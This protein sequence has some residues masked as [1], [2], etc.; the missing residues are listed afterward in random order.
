METLQA[1]KK[2][3]A[4]FKANMTRVRK[5]VDMEMENYAGPD[6]SVLEECL[7]DWRE[8][9]KKLQE[10]EVKVLC[11]EDA[12][13]Q[14]ADKDLPEI[15]VTF[16][17]VKVEINGYRRDYDAGLAAAQ[18][19]A[20]P[21]PNPQQGQQQQQRAPALPKIEIKKPPTLEEDTD[22]R[23]F[24]R[25][26]P[27]W[28]NYAKLV[29]LDK[30]VNGVQVGLFWECCSSGFLRIV[31]HGI[32][33]KT[34]TNRTVEEVLDMIND[35]LR[36]L[37]NPHLD[38]RDLL[39]VRQSEG[40]DYTSL[41]NELRELADYADTRTIT[42]DRLLIAILLQSM[43]DDHD[44][45]KVMEK[46]PGTFAAARKIILDLE[47]ARRG[48]R[49]IGSE[50]KSL[51]MAAAIRNKSIYQRAKENDRQSK[52]APKDCGQCGFRYH[53]RE[54]CPAKDVECRGC[55]RIGHYEK[56]CRSKHTAAAVRYRIGA[57]KLC[58]A[59]TRV[60]REPRNEDPEIKSQDGHD[61]KSPESPSRPSSVHRWK[62]LR[63]K[64]GKDLPNLQVGDNVLVQDRESLQWDRDATII[65]RDRRRYQIKFSSSG[66]VLFRNCRYIRKKEASVQGEADPVQDRVD[67]V[68]DGSI[69][70]EESDKDILVMK[71]ETGSVIARV[72]MKDY[73]NV[74]YEF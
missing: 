13:Q 34:G 8:S 33:I 6:P 63:R 14:D 1:L 61:P 54:D 48:A 51:D 43:E 37:R 35:H 59:G 20:N 58:I 12:T 3:R 45:A 19:P 31:N 11:H 21:P 24:A 60:A 41:C 23:A 65:G 71:T 56:V 25:W 74:P 68:Q 62:R 47:T 17:R 66:T 40:Q 30:R 5:Q 2:S 55:H 49:E 4:G 67:P 15:E 69:E 27:L 16:R 73:H 70:Q 42:E 28:D 9:L 72:N 18:A 57:A 7:E 26:R 32:G 39:Q 52:Q 29:E 64:S 36:S 53:Q 22:H 44:K 50:P 46:N 10:A 38:M